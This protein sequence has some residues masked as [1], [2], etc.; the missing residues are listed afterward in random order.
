[1]AKCLALKSHWV[2]FSIQGIVQYAGA[3]V[4]ESEV[5]NAAAFELVLEID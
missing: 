1:M 2:I 3:R 4:Q 5:Q